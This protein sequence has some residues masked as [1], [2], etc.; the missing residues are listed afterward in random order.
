LVLQLE[1]ICDRACIELTHEFNIFK[2]AIQ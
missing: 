2:D 1:E